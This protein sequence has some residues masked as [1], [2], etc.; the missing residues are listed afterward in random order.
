MSR[1]ADIRIGELD[2][3][4]VPLIALLPLDKLRGGT[5]AITNGGVFSLS[6]KAQLA[7][8]NVID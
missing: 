8:K 7:A 3:L 2:K 5:C 4:A 1:S 6:E